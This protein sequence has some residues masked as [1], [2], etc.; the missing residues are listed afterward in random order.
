VEEIS[1]EK[2]SLV[3][4]KVVHLEAKDDC[5]DEHGDMDIEKAKPLIAVIG[6][7]GTWFT[8]PH[9]GGHYF[10]HKKMSLTDNKK[11]D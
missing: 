6:E 1:R 2:Y 3:I 11:H 8:R 7:E 10:E 5:F 9:P 4:G